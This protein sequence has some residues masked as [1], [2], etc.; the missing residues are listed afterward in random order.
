NIVTS[1][2]ENALAYLRNGGYSLEPHNFNRNK[3]S[4]D[5]F[6]QAIQEISLEKYEGITD[7]QINIWSAVF[8]NVYELN[9]FSDFERKYE[10]CLKT[11]SRKEIDQYYA[12]FRNKD[13]I[14]TINKEINSEN[15]SAFKN[16]IELLYRINPEIKIYTMIIPRFVEIESFGL[17]Y[18]YLHKNIIN[19][20]IDKTKEKYD[21]THIDFHSVSDLPL[22]REYYRDTK[23]LN[24]LGAERITD[25]LCK[26]IFG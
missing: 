12:D 11:L 26:I 16:L 24:T 6:E 15:R 20:I 19:D 17:Y 7:E 5:N 8:G 25:E 23:H 22:T 14:I 2:S 9:S 13:D 1:L 4:D 3:F 10:K 21:F 18:I